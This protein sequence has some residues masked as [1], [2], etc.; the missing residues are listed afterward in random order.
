MVY[1]QPSVEQ[2]KSQT[3]TNETTSYQQNYPTY[4][5]V[6]PQYYVENKEFT[7]LPQYASGQS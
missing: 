7:F 3:A 5:Y 1:L 2:N 4:H 6:A